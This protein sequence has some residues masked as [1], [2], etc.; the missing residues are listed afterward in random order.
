MDAKSAVTFARSRIHGEVH[1]DHA[2]ALFGLVKVF[3]HKDALLLELGVKCGFTMA[4]M[5]MAC[6]LAKIIGVNPSQKEVAQAKRNLAPYKNTKLIQLKS[7]DYLPECQLKF[8]VIF[9]DGDHNRIEKD[10]PWW[11]KV[12]KG[13]LMLFHDYDYDHSRIVYNQLNEFRKQIGR[14]FDFQM[15]VN[16][17]GM[18]GWYK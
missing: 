14:G 6:P 12:K 10:L 17:N 2:K 9:V 3:N 8:D 11:A 4:V 7:W 1:N 13:G 16:G 5:A 18:V 15:T